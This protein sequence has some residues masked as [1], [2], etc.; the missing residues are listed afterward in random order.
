[1]KTLHHAGAISKHRAS[2]LPP[3]PPMRDLVASIDLAALVERY[4]GACLRRSAG[5]YLF[6][7]PNPS[8]PDTSPS[9]SVF[10]GAGGVQ[11]CHCLSQC[12]HIGDALSFLKWL[13]NCDTKTAAN[14]LRNFAGAAPLPTHDYAHAPSKPR[15]LVATA[16]SGLVDD[17]QAMASYLSSRGWPSSVVETFSLQIMKDDYGTKRARHPFY[18]WIGGQ[19]LETGWQARRLDNSKELRWLGAKDTPL[20]L[21]NLQALDRDEITTAIICEGAADTITAHLATEHLDAYACVGVAGAMSWRAEWLQFFSGLRVIVATDNDA[22]GDK[23]L[24]KI[25]EQ[26]D[27]IALQVIAACPIGNDLTDMAKS[28]G[29]E[30]VTALLTS[31]Q[32]DEKHAPRLHLSNAVSR[33][34]TQVPTF[35]RCKVCAK[36]TKHRAQFCEACL[37]SEAITGISWKVCD[38]CETF[39]LVANNRGCHITYACVGSFVEAVRS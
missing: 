14:E 29:L 30:A 35:T 11:R 18:S 25:C 1:M 6:T 19:L 2:T 3:L 37:R 24:E 31:W 33:D 27:G 7:C 5:R 17:G 32:D 39:A 23:L 38:T 34:G 10:V 26:L 16:P 21:Y 36:E 9:F 15:E 8:H 22:A 12:G 28:E 13:N 20:P 4:A